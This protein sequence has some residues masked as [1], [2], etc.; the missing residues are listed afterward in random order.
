M[1]GRKIGDAYVS[2]HGEDSSLQSTLKGVGG[3][4][5]GL[6]AGAGLAKLG[7]MG[8]MAA[9]DMQQAQVGFTTLLHSGAKA[10]DFMK[11]LQSFAAATPFELPGL[12]DTSRLLLGVGVSAKNVIPMLT[13]WGNA[14][15]AM[16]ISGDRFN[17]AMLAVSQS[18]GA[19][20]I[21][22]QDM[23]QIINAG[24]P[25]WNL[26]SEATGKT[27]PQL[28]KLSE[29]GKLLS[30]D[31]LPKVQ[32]Q[33]Q[34]DYGGA[35]AAQSQTLAGVWSTLMDTVRIGMANALGP[36]IPILSTAIPQAAAILSKVLAGASAGMATFFTMFRAGWSGGAEGGGAG[37]I[38]Q[39]GDVSREVFTWISTTGVA[40]L[41]QLV[42]ALRRVV[43]GTADVIR[44]LNS[45]RMALV[46]TL[47]VIGSLIAIERVH[48]AVTFVT[49]GALMAKV[50]AIS[51]VRGA[52]VLYAGAQALMTS[53]LYTWLGVQAIDAAAWAMKA[54]RVVA[55]TAALVAHGVAIAAVRVATLVW[56]G[57]QW[58][59][60]AALT[61]NPIGLVIVAI[62]AL[63]AAIVWVATK[64]TWF[65]TA[66]RATWEFLKM[67]GAW[68]AGPFA[69]FFVSAGNKIA[70][71]WN[72]VTGVVRG[73]FQMWVNYANGA[74][75]LILSIPG[76]IR[77]ALGSLGNL[78]YDAGRS[79]IQG[80]IN[81]IKAMIGAV[82]DAIGGI[83]SKIR[84]NL[85]FSPAKEGPLAGRGNPWYAGRSIANLLAGG[86]TAGGDEVSLSLSRILALPGGPGASQSSTSTAPSGAG[87]TFAPT[88]NVS[89]GIDEQTL[90]RLSV[91]RLTI[92]L[93]AL[94]R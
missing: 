91:S 75:S 70:G 25:I 27:V 74:L 11:Q 12:I 55:S 64:T 58:L 17:N 92:A 33:M 35:M 45:H 40:W 73:A 72:W 30:A 65:Q 23:N 13:A 80:L 71:I 67:I 46:V 26:M 83:A 15:G 68:F 53:G 59:L 20:K 42:D 87:L 7:K 52:M 57:V 51:A 84:A 21:N 4:I 76:R 16:G 34:K 36:L 86:I 66:W 2:I 63:V 89:G 54:V 5:A 29:Q 78:L 56:T 69:G 31:I 28:R 93:S 79:I 62:A 41:Q 38:Q 9:A 18:I 44:W 22:A 48:A 24:I 8:I 77:S 49:G 19:G 61:A 50:V 81:G 6:V 32:A 39:L 3:V 88:Y 1:A 82:G 85:P 90:A 37:A 10:Q 43:D 60:N 94:G 47:G 14:A